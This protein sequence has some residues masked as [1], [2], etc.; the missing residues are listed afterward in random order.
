M[1]RMFGM[2]P[3]N[4]VEVRKTYDDG[5]C[6]LKLKIDAGPNGW[7]LYMADGSTKYNDESK[8]TEANLR[9]AEEVARSFFP[10]MKEIKQN[11]NTEKITGILCK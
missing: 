4:E 8:G 10:R 9:E 1:R 5:L 11:E 2:M 6:G 7:T 3:C